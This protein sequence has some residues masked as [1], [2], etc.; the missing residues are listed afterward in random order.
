MKRSL[1]PIALA[2]LITTACSTPVNQRGEGATEPAAISSESGAV[3]IPAGEVFPDCLPFH[4]PRAQGPGPSTWSWALQGPSPLFP[5]APIQVISQN[6]PTTAHTVQLILLPRVENAMWYGRRPDLAECLAPHGQ[7]LATVDVA[8]GSWHWS[9]AAPAVNPGDN[10]VLV[11][12]DDSGLFFLQGLGEVR[13]QG[14]NKP[15]RLTAGPARS[16]PPAAALPAVQEAVLGETMVVTGSDL[17]VPDGQVRISLGFHGWNGTDDVLLGMA[18][19]QG[20]QFE[21]TVTVPAL[22]TADGGES[23]VLVPSD[24]FL[25][26][27]PPERPFTFFYT[28][29]LRLLPDGRD[30]ATLAAFWREMEAEQPFKDQ[31][32]GF[33]H[34]AGPAPCRMQAGPGAADATCETQISAVDPRHDQV[35]AGN[36]TQE[37]LRSVTL[38]AAWTAGDVPGRH[39][40]SF[41]VGPQGQVVARSEAGD[42]IEQRYHVKPPR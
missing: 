18:A 29:P 38:T 40:W 26:M 3:T 41:V 24:Y 35:P 33:P 39:I 5:G 8:G 23:A 17:P 13:D 7:L 9:G 37:S 16:G 15:F 22:V 31:L 2:L 32:K 20:G 25:V 21:T 36:P 28:T 30:E 34:A 4:D 42:P 10:P 19:V 1:V 27:T 6:W 14:V 11:A 12:V